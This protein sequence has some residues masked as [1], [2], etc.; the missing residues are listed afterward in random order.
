[1]T[2]R[3]RFIL[4][5]E[6]RDLRNVAPTMTVLEWLREEARRP[7]TKEGCAEGDCG[8]C[9]V[10]L[11]EI[12]GDRI[13]Y[14]A[15]NSCIQFVPTLDGKELVTVESL[16]HKGKLHPAQRAMVECH[17][18]QCGFCTPGF[19]MSLFALYHN[20]RAPGREAIDDA[21][22]GNLCR[23]TGYRPIIAAA[24]RMYAIGRRDQF[25]AREAA[26]LAQIRAIAH[27]D[28]L[29]LEHEGQRYFAPKHLDDFAAL[30]ARHP[31]SVLLGGGTDVGLWV[32]KLH[33][34]LDTVI[35]TGDVAE[36]RR[37]EIGTDAIE[38]GGAVTYTDAY[39]ALAADYPDFGEMLRRLGSVQVRNAGTIG[40]NIGNASP[41]GDSP[42][43][44][45][46]LGAAL[47]LRHGATRREMPIAEFFLD[48]RKTVLRPGEF[49]ESIR[50]PRAR[51]GVQFRAYKISKRFDQDISAVCGAFALELK[52]GRVAAI[53]IGFGGMAATPKRA[54]NAEAA[55][56]NQS[57]N[58]TAVRAAMA[59]IARDFQPITDMRASAEYRLKTAQNLLFK[60]FLET[61]G[62][63]GRTRILD[64]EIAA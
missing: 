64:R 11:G 32:T 26:T 6:V 31:D 34:R 27:G 19:V 24:Q 47:L 38:I 1:M 28:T 9:T 56:V 44:L 35:Y 53:R 29:A 18:S 5:G 58:E 7:G 12:D 3:I 36:L 22:A 25:H 30:V 57:W 55:L 41:I 4:D 60:F 8:A 13:R 59:A 17:G 20:E 49:V 16:K 37:L 52:G 54:A 48:Y 40:G 10:A 23:C 2:D 15:I 21:L 63:P 42:P 61:A 39:A 45:L 46:A 14:R 33:R 62:R 43:L 51:P 50:V